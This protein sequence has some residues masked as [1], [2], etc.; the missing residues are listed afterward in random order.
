MNTITIL[1]TIIICLLAG[2]SI[3]LAGHIVDFGRRLKAAEEIL[4]E[5]LKEG[6]EKISERNKLRTREMEAYQ[7]VLRFLEVGTTADE[8]KDYLRKVVKQYNE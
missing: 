2:I 4:L 7:G 6:L 3:I 5:D 8:L 1:S